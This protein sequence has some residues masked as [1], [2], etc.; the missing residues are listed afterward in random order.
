MPE[1]SAAEA[2]FQEN[3][4]DI[5]LSNVMYESTRVLEIVWPDE[6]RAVGTPAQLGCLLDG[7]MLDPGEVNRSVDQSVLARITDNGVLIYLHAGHVAITAELRADSAC[8]CKVGK[9]CYAA[10]PMLLP[11]VLQ[12]TAKIAQPLDHQKLRDNLSYPVYA[13]ILDDAPF[14][15]PE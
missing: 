4:P 15:M 6:K 11:D 2:F 10:S 14:R 1:G 3:L 12:R 5:G 9:N 13:D 7:E 8:E